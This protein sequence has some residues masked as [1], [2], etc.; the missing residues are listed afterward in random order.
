M[1]VCICSTSFR[2]IPFAATTSSNVIILFIIYL[3]HPKLQPAFNEPFHIPL[4]LARASNISYLRHSELETWHSPTVSFIFSNRGITQL[5][6]HLYR[7]NSWNSNIEQR[8]YTK[9]VQDHT[10]TCTSKLS[11][12]AWGL[13]CSRLPRLKRPAVKIF[14]R[15]LSVDCF[16]DFVFLAC[17]SST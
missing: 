17:C 16:T 15:L 4:D 7:S 8:P 12:H 13:G 11:V 1:C 5:L 10:S 3:C 2:L 9:V 6:Q 14:H